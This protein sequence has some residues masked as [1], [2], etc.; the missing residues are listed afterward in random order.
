MFLFL[1]IFV[2]TCYF[3]IFLFVWEYYSSGLLFPLLWYLC[4]FN[5]RFSYCLM[6]LSILFMC[7]LDNL[8]IFFGELFYSYLLPIFW[9]GLGLLFFCY[10]FKHI[11]DM[12][13]SSYMT[14][15]YFLQFV[16]LSFTFPVVF[17][18]Q[19]FLI[20]KF[21]LLNFSF[22]HLCFGAESKKSLPNPAS[23]VTLISNYSLLVYKTTT[24]FVY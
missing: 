11:L 20:M 7:L 24:H 10:K 6:I 13:L 3:L 22:Y 19:M 23:F 8:C 18:V 14:Y 21:S 4:D 16:G 5:Q 15:K 12:S 2:N 9:L 17:S 1:H